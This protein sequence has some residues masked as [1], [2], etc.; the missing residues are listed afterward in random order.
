[1][2]WFA[3]RGIRWSIKRRMRSMGYDMTKLTEN[4][5]DLWLMDYS[6]K[7]YM[8]CCAEDL[9]IAR[10]LFKEQYLAELASSQPTL[11]HEW[12]ARDQ[13]KAHRMVEKAVRMARKAQ[14][15]DIEA[16]RLLQQLSDLVAS[17]KDTGP[18][19]QM[20]GAGSE[21]KKAPVLETPRAESL[22]SHP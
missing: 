8:E 22:M 16:R 6:N 10:H 18:L 20:N 1:M 4:W 14:H 17:L 5:D 2:H 3:W 13:E 19:P 9:R 11:V 21:K 7:V 15:T 12:L